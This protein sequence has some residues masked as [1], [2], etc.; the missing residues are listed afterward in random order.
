MRGNG[1][2]ERNKEGEKGRR[3]GRVRE[4]C[5]EEGEREGGI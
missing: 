1:G 5:G 2:R 4:G 3:K